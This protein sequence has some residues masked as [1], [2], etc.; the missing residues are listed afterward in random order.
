MFKFILLPKEG[1]QGRE[2][3]IPRDYFSRNVDHIDDETDLLEYS[4][5]YLRKVHPEHYCLLDKSDYTVKAAKLTL[6]DSV[7]EALEW[8]RSD[9][10][11]LKEISSPKQK[12]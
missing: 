12:V 2:F 8:L 3:E 1:H 5:I 4:W 9:R 7:N 11:Y 10:E 6:C